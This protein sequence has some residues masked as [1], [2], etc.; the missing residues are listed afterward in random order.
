MILTF[1][2]MKPETLAEERLL[3]LMQQAR[4]IAV[5]IDGIYDLALYRTER[6]HMWQCTIDTEDEQA[7]ELLQAH[8]R[9]REVCAA[10]QRLSFLP[11]Q[12]AIDG[13]VEGL[14]SFARGLRKVFGLGRKNH[15]SR[16]TDDR[17]LST[18]INATLDGLGEIARLRTY[19]R[20]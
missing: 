20:N 7:W 15:T 4:Q 12:G 10:L 2:V 8:S 11:L 1:R 6:A 13:L 18:R 14:G 5:E 16:D 19:A 9:S 17:K 3:A